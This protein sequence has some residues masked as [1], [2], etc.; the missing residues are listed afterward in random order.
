MAGERTAY[1]RPPPERALAKTDVLGAADARG[2]DGFKFVDI[3]ITGVEA[4]R[5]GAVVGAAGV[6][7][8]SQSDRNS[9]RFRKN[10]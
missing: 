2:K 4:E 9:K 10:N 8:W 3:V 7:T 5:A 1:L 6:L